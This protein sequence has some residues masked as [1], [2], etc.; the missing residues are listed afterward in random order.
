[1]IE[2][3][4]SLFRLPLIFCSWTM[5]PSHL[6]RWGR[7]KGN[8]CG[9]GLILTQGLKALLSK[10][11]KRRRSVTKIIFICSTKGLSCIPLSAWLEGIL[12]KLFSVAWVWFLT[13]FQVGFLLHLRAPY[14][15][16]STKK[17]NF[18]FRDVKAYLTALLWLL[19]TESFPFL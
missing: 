6:L 1:M 16:P 7:W 19:W 10:C 18:Q 9:D 12:V 5:F 13:W 8:I 14:L 11:K 15:K 4:L 3:D 17:E 2:K